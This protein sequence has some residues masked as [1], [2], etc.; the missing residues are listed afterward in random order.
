MN[1]LKNISYFSD[2]IKFPHKGNGVA[3]TLMLKSKTIVS[4]L[5][6]IHVC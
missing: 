3:Q 5:A 4:E 6:I 2:R 1:F